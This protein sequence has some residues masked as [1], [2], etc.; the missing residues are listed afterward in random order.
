MK[1]RYGSGQRPGEVYI[2]CTECTG[3]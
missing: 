1:V 3:C 2:V